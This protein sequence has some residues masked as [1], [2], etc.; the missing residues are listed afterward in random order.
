MKISDIAADEAA[1]LVPL[2]QDL[3]A[4]HAENQPERY[5]A[6]PTDADLTEW[7]TEWLAT[8]GTHAIAAQSPSGAVMGY[9]I[10]QIETRPTLPIVRGGKRVMLHQI[11]VDTPFRSQGV[12]SRLI[13]EIQARCK[14]MEIGT[15]VTTYATFNTASAA[16]MSRMGLT[17]VTTVAEW[18]MG[19]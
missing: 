12:G 10:Y 5:P 2:L 3:H 15:L 14:A 4:L 17:P 7:L 8:D 18:R 1:R 9:A 6:N 11:M 16:L 13:K 19:A